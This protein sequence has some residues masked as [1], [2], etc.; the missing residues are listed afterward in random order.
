MNTPT[1]RREFLRWQKTEGGKKHSQRMHARYYDAHKARIL[2]WNTWYRWWKRHKY[3]PFPSPPCGC[4]SSQEGDSMKK[5]LVL[6][7]ALV[8]FTTNA[9]AFWRIG[10]Q[11]N[12]TNETGFRIERKVGT[13][14]YTQIGQVG[15]G[16]VTYDDTTSVV[17][18]QYCYRIVSYNTAG[19]T[20]GAE[21]CAIATAPAAPGAAV[22]IWVP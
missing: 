13:A 8:F 2:N 16:V 14:A 1:K 12:S 20:P 5:P 6:T 17:G 22:L 21:T 18:T 9:H 4:C 3:Q 10:W 19:T 7:L 11:D 15:A